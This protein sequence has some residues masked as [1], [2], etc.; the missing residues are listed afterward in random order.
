MFLHAT[1]HDVNVHT[2]CV[3]SCAKTHLN[4]TSTEI[5][6][7]PVV[8]CQLQVVENVLENDPNWKRLEL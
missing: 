7:T 8:I 2:A 1:I 5:T 4:Q 3:C 6:L